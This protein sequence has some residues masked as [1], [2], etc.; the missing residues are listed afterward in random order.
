MPGARPHTVKGFMRTKIVCFPPSIY[1]RQHATN[2]VAVGIRGATKPF[3]RAKACE[4][5]PVII[6][7]GYSQFATGAT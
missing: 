6:F 3:L 5:T 4:T 1:L 2:P 7:I